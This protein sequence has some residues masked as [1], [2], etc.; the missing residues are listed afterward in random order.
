DGSI[1]GYRWNWGDEIVVNAADSA[2]TIVGSAWARTSQSGA[3]GGVALVNPD[4]GAAKITAAAASPSSYVEV[5]AYAAAGVP[6]HVWFRMQAQGDSYSNDSMFVQFSGAVTAA[7]AALDRIGTTAAS[8]VILENG[9]GAGVSGW[10]WNDDGYGTLGSP[11]YF[12]TS[13]LQTIRV[14]QREDGVMW[15]QLVLSAGTYFTARP[16]LTRADSTIVVPQSGSGM[17]TSH[18][19]PAAGQYPVQLTVTDNGGATASAWTSASVAASAGSTPPPSSTN[20]SPVA[21]A[22]GPYSG[23]RG[24]ALTVDGSGSSDADGSIAAYRWT[25]GDE[26]VVRAADTAATAIVGSAWARASQSGAADGVALVNPDKGAAKKTAAAASPSSYVEVRFYAAAG[27]PY[28]VWFRMRAEGDAYTNDSMFVQFSGAVTA[29]G[30]AVNRIG[31]TA[32]SIVI[33]ENGSG[34]GMSGWGWND[35]GYGTLGSAVY[36]AASGLQT[37]RVQQREDGVMWDQLVVS[38]GTYVTTR[39]GSTQGDSTVLAVTSSSGASP[40]HVYPAV[41]QYPIELTVTDD[42]GAAGSALTTAT[43]K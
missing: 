41:G 20:A 32:A 30:S 28:H 4:K 40:S 5:Q 23:A 27:V 15:D 33:L 38:A 8:T 9:K 22:G 3:A 7:G 39:P 29:A 12:A 35:D 18:V 34:A 10:G 13:G 36:F 16:G 31:T 11:V 25:W 1:S 24:S 37:M 2:A 17:V 26:V 43:I 21:N 14:Q 19:Y 42:K 6:Y